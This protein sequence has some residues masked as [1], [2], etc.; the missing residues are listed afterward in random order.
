MTPDDSVRGWERA[1]D[2]QA[3][4]IAGVKTVL[5]REDVPSPLAI[6]G[7]GGVGTLLLCHLLGE[8][9]SRRYEQP[10]SEGGNFY[11]FTRDAWSVAHSW[12]PIDG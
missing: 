3:R 11:R 12:R 4:I 7:H 1:R 2:A 6:V 9:I 8:P 5:G 10:G